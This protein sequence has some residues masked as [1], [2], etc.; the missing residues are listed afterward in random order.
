MK[1]ILYV[2][3][4]LAIGGSAYFTLEHSRKFTDVQKERLELIAK[5]KEVSANADVK[6]ND[7]K[8]TQEELE[9]AQTKR[10]ELNASIDALTSTAKSVQ[11]DISEVEGTIAAQDQEF[12]ELEKTIQEVNKVIAEIGDQLGEGDVTLAELPAKIEEID[13]QRKESASK[14]AELEQLV[15]G[16]E[17]SLASLRSELDRLQ[18]RMSQRSSR[19]SRNSMQAVVTA[20]NQD[21]GFLVIGAGSNSGFT[22]QT[23]LIVQRDGQMIGRVK[24]S[25]IEPSQTIAE[26]DFDSMRSGVR[27]QPGDRVILQKPATN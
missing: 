16:G 19:I 26:I 11:R 21:Y 6:E 24:P 23:S 25:S 3:A 10:S 14:L 9:A 4:L 7:L 5:N 1:A 13:N 20:V 12:E 17:K 27:I 18:K 2:V 15:E 8:K 22:P